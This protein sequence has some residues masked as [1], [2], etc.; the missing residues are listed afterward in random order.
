MKFCLDMYTPIM[1]PSQNQ[2]NEHPKKFPH[3]S[4]SSIPSPLPSPGTN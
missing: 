1:K 4:L 3:V 2:D